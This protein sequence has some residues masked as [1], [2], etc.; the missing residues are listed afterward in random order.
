MS[1]EEKEI[2][3]H[4]EAGRALVAELRPKAD[5]VSKI[6]IIPRGI[7]ALG[8][9]QQQPTEDRYLLACRIARLA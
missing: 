1:A 9:T 5:R 3:A 7:A 4:H 6:S 2:I 8:Y